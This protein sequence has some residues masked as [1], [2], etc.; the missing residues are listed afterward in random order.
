[1]SDTLTVSSDQLAP[2]A[3]QA[4]TR[5]L[6]ASI[7]RHGSA[8]AKIPET[9]SQAGERGEPVTLGLL[10]LTFLSSGGVVALF[11]VFKAYIE[12][13]SS[14]EL[15]LT[16]ADGETMVVNAKNL[17]SNDIGQALAAAQNFFAESDK[18]G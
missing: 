2:G 5:D 13:D 3:L 18:E 7:N 17:H 1:M 10:V 4:L 14:L 12:R 9:E 6:A 15:S 16:R 11:E 8:Q